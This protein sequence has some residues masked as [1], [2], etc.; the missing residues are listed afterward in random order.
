MLTM[1]DFSPSDQLQEQPVLMFP[2]K[3]CLSRL[4]VQ[5]I[6]LQEVF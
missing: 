4:R 6:C 2:A 3:L 5:C 1:T